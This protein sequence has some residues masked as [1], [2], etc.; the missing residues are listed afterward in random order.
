MAWTKRQLVV[1]AFDEIGL[2]E[3]VFDIQ[4]EQL[5]SALRRLDAMAASWNA[6]GLYFGY[7]LPSSPGDSDL[8]DEVSVPDAAAEALYLSLAIR[9]APSLGKQV[10]IETKTS[11]RQAYN[12][13]LMNCRRL[14]QM[15]LP[16]HMP[17]GAGNKQMDTEQVYVTPP[18]LDP[19]QVDSSDHLDFVGN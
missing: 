13:L 5:E 19:L 9:L 7:P 12:A 1:Q 16:S 11:A 8:D 6:K 14:I 15:Q 10:A 17:L 4:P 18:D 2:A 3:Y